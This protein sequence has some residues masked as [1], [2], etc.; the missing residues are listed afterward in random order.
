MDDAGAAG[1]GGGD[2]ERGVI[3]REVLT[4]AT[5]AAS[6]HNT[7][8]WR[9]RSVGNTLEILPDFSR[10]TPVVDP[11]GHH[12][13]VSLGCA[14]E[15]AVVAATAFG[16]AGH[17]EFAPCAG[18]GA[19]RVVFEKTAAPASP[20]ADAIPARQCSRAVYDG[21]AV[22]ATELSQLAADGIVLVTDRATLE[23]IGEYVAEGN[24]A[25][26]GDSAFVRELVDWMRFT[27]REA[28]G[29]GDGLYGPA[30]GMPALPRALGAAAMRL[31]LR[32]AR[33][34]ARDLTALRGSAGVAAFVSE[35]D[36]P[37]GWVDTG[38]RYERFA[39][40]ATR[41]GVRTALMNQPVEVR[42]LR[43]GVA[44]ALGVRGRP[45]LLVRFGYGPER[46]RSFRR[47]LEAVLA[48]PGG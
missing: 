18:G 41:L 11:D 17:A 39:L 26:L 35:Q 30:F 36:E 25:Q 14:A 4:A 33:Q 28:A 10:R 45:S 7:Q 16:L 21:R 5:L 15:N 43:D 31:A 34:N 47:P 42:A 9:L 48:Q 19:V 37:A 13:Y 29:H 27:R 44:G 46:P 22:A 6:S 12:L 8:P 40:E 24:A 38:R 20:L 1:E 2:A 3:P 23:S 32:P